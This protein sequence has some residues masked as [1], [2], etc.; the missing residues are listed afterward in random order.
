M[1]RYSLAGRTP[2]PT[3]VAIMNGRRYSDASPP[4]AG[5]HAW[6]CWTSASQA[7]M[8]SLGRQLR[9]RQPAGGALEALGVDLRARSLLREGEAVCVFPE[10][11]ISTAYVVRA[12]MPGAVA[13]ARET[14]APLVP[15]SIWGSQRLWAQ[16]QG[17]RRAA[18]RPDLTR[19]RLVDVR[20]GAPMTVPPA[21]TWPRRPGPWATGCTT[22]SRSSRRC[23]STGRGRG[24]TRPGTP[25]TSAGTPWTG[26]SPSLSTACPDRPLRRPGAREPRVGL[27]RSGRT[28]EPPGAEGAAGGGV[29][30]DHP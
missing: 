7:S 9:H 29:R 4:W 20:F 24:S 6:S 13:L 22:G 1:K 3:S 12:L 26:P 18:A 11:G 8:N 30:R 16:K 19:G 21:R 15:V 25:R 5:T 17:P 27:W 14:G 28:A 10:G 2:R 23:P